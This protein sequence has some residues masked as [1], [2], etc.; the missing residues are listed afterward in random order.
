MALTVNGGI[1]G[2][3]M[4]VFIVVPGAAAAAAA[5]GPP[6]IFEAMGTGGAAEGM[7]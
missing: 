7:L 2:N 5:A 6:N 3:E 1:P 4:L